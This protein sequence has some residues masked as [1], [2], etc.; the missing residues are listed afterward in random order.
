MWKSLKQIFNSPD[1]YVSLALGLAVVLI[2]GMISFNYFKTKSQIAES[3]KVKQQN[4]E[5]VKANSTPG[6]Y[7]VKDGDTLWSIAQTIYK[8]GYNWVDIQKANNLVN[9]DYI[10][11]GQ[12]LTLPKISPT[13]T[14]QGEISA[15]STEIPYTE[16]HYTVVAGDD[17][18]S[19]S[20]KE[21][22]GNGY[23][24]VDIAKANNLTNPDIINAGN[25]LVLP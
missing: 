10:M 1:S 21:Y 17:L 23:R 11:T 13:P 24:W 18:W 16:K 25:V 3:E 7:M 6:N 12:S 14:P 20:Q 5:M 22:N 2:I 15:A 4:Q 19:I 8:S 9:A